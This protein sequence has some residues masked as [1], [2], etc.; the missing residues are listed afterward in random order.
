MISQRQVRQRPEGDDAQIFF[1]LLNLIG[2]EDG[3][4]LLLNM[5]LMLFIEKLLLEEV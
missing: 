3:S 1:I 4:K 2:D 5:L